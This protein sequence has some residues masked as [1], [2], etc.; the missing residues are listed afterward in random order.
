MPATV[1][2]RLLDLATHKWHATSLLASRQV[3]TDLLALQNWEW[4]PQQELLVVRGDQKIHLA[5]EETKS[6]R[7]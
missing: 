7:S 3:A 6:N 5:A 2:F 4:W 1:C